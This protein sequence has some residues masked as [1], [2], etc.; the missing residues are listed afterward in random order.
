[1]HPPRE[2]EGVRAE[3][4][5]EGKTEMRT[6]TGKEE[7]EVMTGAG[8]RRIQNRMFTWAETPLNQDGKTTILCR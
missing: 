2:E 8:H 4:R 7:E 3:G 6:G 5:V 1:M